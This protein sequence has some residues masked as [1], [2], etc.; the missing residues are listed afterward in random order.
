M[1]L[2]PSSQEYVIKIQVLS[3][4]LDM[5]LIFP[6]GSKDLNDPPNLGKV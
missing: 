5:K 2:F 3:L 4:D 6:E 1:S